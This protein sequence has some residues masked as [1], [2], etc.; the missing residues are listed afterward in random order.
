MTPHSTTESHILCSPL[1]PHSRMPTE[2]GDDK[3]T[4]CHQCAHGPPQLVQQMPIRPR[5]Q[6][7]LRRPTRTI[8]ENPS[9]TCAH[10]HTMWP[11]SSG[12]SRE[13]LH[14]LRP[15]PPRHTLSQ[16]HTVS[17]SSHEHFVSAD[18]PPSVANRT[19]LSHHLS[20]TRHPRQATSLRRIGRQA[21]KCVHFFV[22][23]VISQKRT[24]HLVQTRNASPI[25]PLQSECT[26]LTVR[27]PWG[28]PRPQHQKS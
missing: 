2:E 6:P 22:P 21:Q 24:A 14:L 19:R 7:P 15:Y 28:L 8:N 20:H 1:D 9:H 18:P 17:S 26:P 16:T 4:N 25:R 12:Q 5:I 10:M 13:K 11:N 27:I 3:Q 23:H